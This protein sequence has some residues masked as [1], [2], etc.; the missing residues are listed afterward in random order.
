LT[1]DIQLG[2]DIGQA[3]RLLRFDL[4]GC[5]EKGRTIRDAVEPK[6]GSVAMAFGGEAP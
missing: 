1:E 4:L 3:F 6:T 5:R 2:L